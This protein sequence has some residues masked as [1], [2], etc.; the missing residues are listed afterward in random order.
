LTSTENHPKANTNTEMLARSALFRLYRRTKTLLPNPTT[1]LNGV[2]LSKVYKA[3]SPVQSKPESTSEGIH[4]IGEL[5]INNTKAPTKYDTL[6]EHKAQ[7][8]IFNIVKALQ[9]NDQST[10]QITKLMEFLAG[11]GSNEVCTD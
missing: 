10:F 2:S 8:E 1:S 3:T 7:S 11:I 9:R 4:L 5:L 6:I